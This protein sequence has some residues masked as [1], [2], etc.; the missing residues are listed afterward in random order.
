MRFVVTGGEGFIG[1]NIVSQLRDGGHEVLSLDI[2]GR[3]D[4]L[5]SVLD[6]E[7]LRKVFS[8]ADGVFHLAAVTSPP[9]FEENPQQGFINNVTG[10]LNVVLAGAK[11]KVR[12]I[13]FA[14]SSA[15]YGMSGRKTSESMQVLAHNNLYPITKVIGELLGKYAF[16]RGETEFVSLRYFNA[17]GPGE[18]TK[19]VYSSV[20]WK[21]IEASLGGK[22]LVI[23]GDG[24]Q[25]RDF[26][27][28]TDV[29]K[30]TI[31]AFDRG[32]NG[33]CYNIGSGVSTD[34]NTIAR[35]VKDTLGTP[36]RIV[37]V[38]NPL[39]NYQNYTL[40]DISKIRSETGWKPEIGLDEG[41]KMTADRQKD[42]S[43]H[44][45]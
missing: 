19:S 17:Y 12:R 13:A 35:M 27:Y 8:G 45:P 1:R 33:E 31:E 24:T 32:R 40:A 34:F 41:I 42:G 10:T 30:A 2:N 14:S 21:F 36:S 16:L 25:S 20:I 44:Q 15:T 43:S 11:E 29:A 6:Y 22:D 18:N 37:H 7:A 4:R 38:D 23:Y 39:K 26:I 28:V 3:P 9:Q 5:V